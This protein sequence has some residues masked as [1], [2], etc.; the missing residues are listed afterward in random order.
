MK[1]DIPDTLYQSYAETLNN[2]PHY[3]GS[4]DE[5][6][7]HLIKLELR[8]LAALG[9]G[10]D[11]LT[12]CKTNHQLQF[13]LTEALMR[14]GREAP[15]LLS[16]KYLCIDIDNFKH[17]LDDH[18]PG[19]GDEAL[20]DIASQL[21]KRYTAA[22]VY[23]FGGDEFVVHLGSREYLP[24]EPP[25]GIRIKHSIVDVV[26]QTSRSRFNHLHSLIMLY[27]HRGVVESEEQGK[28]IVFRYPDAA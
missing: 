3:F 14:N 23:R 1:V 2:R 24:L 26:A 6:I 17:F 25:I 21:I 9:Y 20:V 27:I 12:G 8:R 7:Q 18:G 10:T 5:N 15:A 28:K 16:T 11:G 4:V 22:N 19:K 13:D